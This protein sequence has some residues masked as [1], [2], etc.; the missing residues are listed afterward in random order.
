MQHLEEN[1]FIAD[2]QHGFVKM[3]SCAT[4][5][6][7]FYDSVTLAMDDHKPVDAIFLDF[8]KA[9]DKVPHKALL[10]KLRSYGVRGKV[11]G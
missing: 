4:N 9:F 1:N 7:E 5:L 3:R 6:I 8:A 11:G 10:A 2:E